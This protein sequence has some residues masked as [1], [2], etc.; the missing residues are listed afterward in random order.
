MHDSQH[1]FAFAPYSHTVHD[2]FVEK[3]RDGNARRR[4]RL[5][6][7]TTVEDA[8]AYREEVRRAIKE[9][10][11]PFP[12]KTPLKTVKTGRKRRSGYKIEKLLFESRPG[13]KVTA[14]LYV[15][16]GARERQHPGVIAA[17]GHS[18]D[19]KAE[20]KYQEFCQRLVQCGFVVL[21]YDPINQGER[22]QYYANDA[23][24]SLKLL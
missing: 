22:N 16:A 18:I 8:V 3:I 11:A 24:D 13:V 7:I 12:P 19:G 15:P 10:F 2:Y 23:N 20:P 1:Y 4:R 9:S 6:S 14:N 21:I 5:A 17:C